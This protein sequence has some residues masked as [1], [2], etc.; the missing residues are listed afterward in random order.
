MYKSNIAAA[1][2][3]LVNATGGVING[4][5]DRAIVVREMVDAA[6]AEIAKNNDASIKSGCAQLHEALKPI[7]AWLHE[8]S[9]SVVAVELHFLGAQFDKVLSK[10]QLLEALLRPG[11]QAVAGLAGAFDV[12]LQ[13]NRSTSSAIRLVTP[14]LALAEQLGTYHALIALLGGAVT[15]SQGKEFSI[16]EMDSADRLDTFAVLMS[17]LAYLME[18]ATTTISEIDPTGQPPS[19]VT[20]ESIESGS[21]IQ[22]RLG[23]NGKTVR[24]LLAMIRDAIRW[25]FLQFS[26]RGRVLQ[27]I[28]TYAYAN[29]L[30]INSPE[31][32]ANLERAIAHASQ[33]YVEKLTENVAIRIDGEKVS[34]NPPLLLPPAIPEPKLDSSGPLILPH[35][36]EE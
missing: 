18:I 12:A 29:K 26:S 11:R 15:D 27:A 8:V 16:I 33:Q 14:S 2:S 1:L 30:G 4:L 5:L 21:P 13:Q 35:G 6:E 22:I 23:G 9:P 28:D 17:L 36:D 34:E 31:V 19:A 3:Q 32:L 20:I 24:F 7:R 10:Y 25:P